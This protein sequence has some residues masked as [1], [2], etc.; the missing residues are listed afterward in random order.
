MKRWRAAWLSE[1]REPFGSVMAFP[2]EGSFLKRKF[3]LF[4][5]GGPIASVAALGV[6]IF[7]AYAASDRGSIALQYFANSALLSAILMAIVS[8]VPFAENDAATILRVL[9]SRFDPTKQFA[10][11]GLAGS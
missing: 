1:Q 2:T 6:T 4:S 8:L 9:L 3:L 10:V 11:L 7:F 5:A